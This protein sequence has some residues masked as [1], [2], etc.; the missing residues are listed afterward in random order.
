[1]FAY[2]IAHPDTYHLCWKFIRIIYFLEKEIGIFSYNF[3]SLK[4]NYEMLD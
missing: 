2:I 1:M 4:Y 3:L